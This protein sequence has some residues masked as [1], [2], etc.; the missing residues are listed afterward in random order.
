MRTLNKFHPFA[1]LAMLAILMAGCAAWEQPRTF[2]Q[3]LAYAYG[4]H[5]ALLESAANAVELGTLSPDDAGQ[6]LRIA[7][8][9]RVLLDASRA[10]AGVGDVRTAE[11]Q[12]AL[13][14]NLLTQLQTYINA[15]VKK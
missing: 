11:G 3:Q 14:T 7:D 13:A 15:R 6:V 1:F 2:E 9:S 5:T 4:T 10:A 8:E 12:L